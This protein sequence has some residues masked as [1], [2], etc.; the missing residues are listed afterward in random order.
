VAHIGN[1]CNGD[2]RRAANLYVCGERNQ[3]VVM[4]TSRGAQDYRVDT[5][6]GQRATTCPNIVVVS[7]D[8]TVI[9]SDPSYGRM[10]GFWSGA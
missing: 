4:E 8:N 3:D 5:G 10:P 2:S 7:S 1:K 9:F 6:R